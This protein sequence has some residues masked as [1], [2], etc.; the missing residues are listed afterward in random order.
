MKPR[1][2]LI[3]VLAAVLTVI[4]P[5]LSLAER[6]VNYL[7]LKGGVY[8][9]GETYDLNGIHIDTGNGFVVGGAF[10]H[11]FLPFLAL[12]LEG[13]YLESKGSATGRPGEST[14]KA[15]PALLTGKILL[16]VGPVEPFGE[17]GFGVYAAELDVSGIPGDFGA[18]KVIFVYY[19]GG[20]VN[21][22]LTKSIFLGGEVRYLWGEQSFGGQ[23]VKLDG[24]T[25]T[26]SL[27]FRY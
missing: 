23:N 14:L 18:T 24:I 3:L 8:S 7:M 9:P 13:G 11:Y 6:P 10:G 26:G 20:G 17:F 5:G 27:G 25:A 1:Y 12:E 16:P 19:A 22:D 2:A 4:A 15:S 21:V